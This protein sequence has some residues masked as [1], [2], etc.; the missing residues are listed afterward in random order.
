MEEAGHWLVLLNVASDTSLF[1]TLL[2][3]H[4]KVSQQPL[5]CS[6]TMAS[7]PPQA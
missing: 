7:C 3:I 4:Q 6:A 2:P 1:F 5:P